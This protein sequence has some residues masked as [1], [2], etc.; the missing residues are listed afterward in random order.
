MERV[1]GEQ[2]IAAIALLGLI[3]LGHVL[4]FNTLPPAN[5]TILATIVGALAGAL[6]VAGGKK[7]IDAV[8]TTGGTTTINTGDTPP[9]ETTT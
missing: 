7:A 1:T 6:T 9:T 5:A 2:I 8:K 4:V 3:V